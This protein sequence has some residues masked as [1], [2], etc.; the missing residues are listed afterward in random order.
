MAGDSRGFPGYPMRDRRWWVSPEQDNEAAVPGRPGAEE[1][2]RVEVPPTERVAALEAE[3]ADRDRRLREA[4]VREREASLEVDLARQRLERDAR[5]EI[6]RSRRE[7]VV[8]LLPVLDDLDRA[9]SAARERGEAEALVTGVEHVR[10]GFLD[11]LRGFGV[12]RFDPTGQL[13]DPARHEAVTTVEPSA[14]HRSGLIVKTLL[15]GYATDGE[16]I[17]PAQVIVAGRDSRSWL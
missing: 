7:L 4:L 15:P 5:K 17:R 6:E 11:R 8:A 1:P 12:E 3:L 10:S 16:T 9:I 13:F 2:P 14:L